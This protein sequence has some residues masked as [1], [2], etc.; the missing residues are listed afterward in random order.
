MAKNPIPMPTLSLLRPANNNRV[1]PTTIASRQQ[2][3]RPANN[4]RAPPTTIAS[5]QQQLHP[6]NNNCIPPTATAS[7]Q[8]QPRPANNNRAAPT[9][10]ASGQQQ[11]RRANNNRL[12]SLLHGGNDLPGEAHAPSFCLYIPAERH[13]SLEFPVSRSYEPQRITFP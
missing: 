1:P 11:L 2:R 13:L 8:Q 3:L 10:T 4:N 6:A 12:S 7:R 5:R 9:T